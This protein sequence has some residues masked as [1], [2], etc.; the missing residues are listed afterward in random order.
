MT[1]VQK[2]YKPK[3]M[4]DVAT[5]TGACM[6]ALGRDTAGL[7]TPHECL[8]KQIK[9]ASKHSFEPVWE[10]PINEEHKQAIKGDFCD[11]Y[12]CGKDKF[13]GASTA[14]AFLQK[15]V[16]KGTKWAHIDIAGPAIKTGV[17]AK[18][19]INNDQTGFGASLLLNFIRRN[20]K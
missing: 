15:F 16:E 5:L 11:L 4:I 3:K 14:A 1:F 9:E 7:F 6:V 2:N 19:P 18:P 17:P 10:L 12:N 8:S 13:G 20:I